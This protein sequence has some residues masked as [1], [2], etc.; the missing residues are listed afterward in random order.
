MLKGR[1]VTTNA[2]EA[3]GVA[4]SVAHDIANALSAIEGAGTLLT[5]HWADMSDAQRVD[6]LAIVAVGSHRCCAGC[7]TL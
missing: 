4:N 7:S 6:M 2:T 1:T 3:E 5:E